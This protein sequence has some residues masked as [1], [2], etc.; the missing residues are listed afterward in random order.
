ML[1]T[2]N[3][4]LIVLEIFEC[5]FRKPYSLLNLNKSFSLKHYRMLWLCLKL[6]CQLA[7][8]E[9]L[10]VPEYLKHVLHNFY[11]LIFHYIL[12][13]THQEYWLVQLLPRSFVRCSH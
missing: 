12:N 11:F 10:H 5:I 13:I 8:L 6:C 7:V 9:A 2:T 3:P 4:R 1:P